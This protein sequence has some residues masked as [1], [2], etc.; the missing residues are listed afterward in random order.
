MIERIHQEVVKAVSAPD[1]QKRLAELGVEARATSPEEMKK[2]FAAE[3][4]RWAKVVED[5][6]IPKQ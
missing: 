3:T 4:Q 5:A 1:V 2:F 6:K